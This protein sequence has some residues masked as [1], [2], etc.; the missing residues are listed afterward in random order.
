MTRE[1]LLPEIRNILRL[2]LESKGSAP[3]LIEPDTLLYEGG[4]GLDSM[5]TA[6]FAAMLAER[7][8]DDPYFS[9]ILPQNVREVVDYYT[10][11]SES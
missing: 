3:S 7:F 4:L 5:D 2:L 6:T 10:R 8:G 11:S 1:D 9:E